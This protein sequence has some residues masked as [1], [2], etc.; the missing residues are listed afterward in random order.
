MKSVGADIYLCLESLVL[1]RELALSLSEKEN[2]FFE[3]AN[4]ALCALPMSAIRLDL[5]VAKITAISSAGVKD[6][7]DYGRWWCA[8]E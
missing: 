3:F 6:Y 7:R 5:A 1:N 8:A 4:V 2:F